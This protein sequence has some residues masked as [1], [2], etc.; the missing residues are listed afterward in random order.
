MQDLQEE[1]NYLSRQK[2]HPIASNFY[3]PRRSSI[4][5]NIFFQATELSLLLQWC[6]AVGRIYGVPVS[7]VIKWM[8]Q[9]LS[10][11]GQ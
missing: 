9:F 3:N 10:I 4:E 1:I 2:T 8:L 6:R 11:L 7:N 5:P